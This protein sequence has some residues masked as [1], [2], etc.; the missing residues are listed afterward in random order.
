MN[1]IANNCCGAYWY[2]YNDLQFNNPFVWMVL[3]YPYMLNLAMQYKNIDFTKIKLF[4]GNLDQHDYYGININENINIEYVHYRYKENV[5]NIQKEGVELFSKNIH[6]F[7]VD[8]F[9]NRTARMLKLNEDPTFLI[10]DYKDHYYT[11]N[12]QHFIDQVKYDTI[13]F[14]NN[15]YKINRD[16]VQ[17]ILTKEQSITH[18]RIQPE[19][20]IKTYN[21]DINNA[22]KILSYK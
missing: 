3:D 20:F 17:L 10:M 22:I 15:N 19:D 16:N 11:E 1:L 2:K 9:F 4:Q 13:I 8:K 18:R 6:K 14:T 12:T 21:N 5:E 7:T